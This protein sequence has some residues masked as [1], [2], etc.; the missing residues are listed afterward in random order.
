MKLT[1]TQ[2]L[3]IPRERLFEMLCE[4]DRYERSALRRGIEVQRKDSLRNVQ[5][6]MKWDI[7]FTFR[8]KPRKA[9]LRLVALNSP[10]DMQFEGGASG[11]KTHTKIELVALSRSKTRMM[12]DIETVATNLTA[13]LL[14]QSF[15]LA[16]GRANKR[17]GNRL[18]THARELEQ[19]YRTNG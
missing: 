16:R 11:I 8:G 3:D 19:M 10:D 18:D 2:T 14:L 9:K 17:L 7:A 13:R 1:A 4:F 15:K 12:I 5:V 6:G